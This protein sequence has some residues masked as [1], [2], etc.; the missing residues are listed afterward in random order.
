MFERQPFDTRAYEQRIKGGSCFICEMIAGKSEG[1]HIVYQD[2]RA[3]VF[4][5]KYPT[6]YG[7]TLVAPREHREQVT[8]DFTVN[9]YLDLQR[10]IHR[11]GEAV[12][13]E[14]DAERVYI[15]SLGSQQGN[16]HVHWHVAPLPHG[17]PFEEQQLEALRFRNGVLKIPDEEMAAHAVRLRARLEKSKPGTLRGLA[18]CIFRKGDEILVAEGR[19]EVKHETFY[20][21]LGGNIEFGERSA[22]TIVRELREE[23]GA[24]VTGLRYL[25]TCENIFTYQ[26][27]MGHEIVMVYDGALSDRSLYD[28]A[29]IAGAEDSGAPFKAMWKSLDYFRRKGAAPLY[30]DGL[31]DLLMHEKQKE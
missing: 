29:A 13:A 1:N 12:R 25:G 28:Q 17:V 27:E 19:D 14:T 11:V 18:I 2:E 15:L 9:Q 23:I 10:L 8:G 4:L 31:L 24:E 20:R 7:Y 3:I 16:R 6:L 26:G 21:P 30:P 22:E 5:N